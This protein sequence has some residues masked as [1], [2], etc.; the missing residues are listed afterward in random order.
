MTVNLN[1]WTWVARLFCGGLDSVLAL[2]L[3]GLCHRDT[4]LPPRCASS[5]STQVSKCY[6]YNLG[7]WH[8]A[9]SSMGHKIWHTTPPPSLPLRRGWLPRNHYDSQVVPRLKGILLTQPSKH[10]PHERR[11]L[12]L[13]CASLLTVFGLWDKPDRSQR[14]LWTPVSCPPHLN[15]C[16][17][18][19]SVLLNH[20]EGLTDFSNTVIAKKYV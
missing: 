4:T 8:W 3:N 2:W 16:I 10:W 11:L 7:C 1:T 13:L 12:L 5:R 19:A 15:L 6:S 18:T 14:G 9:S 17:Q 20:L